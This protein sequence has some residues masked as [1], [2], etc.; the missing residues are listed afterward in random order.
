MGKTV[1]F[2][3]FPASGS[4]VTAA[5]VLLGYLPHLLLLLLLLSP[6]SL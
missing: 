1:D 3:R 4:A 5:T 6:A 2:L